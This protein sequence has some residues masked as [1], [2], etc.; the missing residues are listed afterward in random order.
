M[1]IVYKCLVFR[2]SQSCI[3]IEAYNR[4]TKRKHDSEVTNRKHN[5]YFC[6]LRYSDTQIILVNIILKIYV[7]IQ[8]NSP[9][10]C[11]RLPY[12]E[13]GEINLIISPFFIIKHEKSKKKSLK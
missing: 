6:K 7:L 4:I 9:I 8:F 10:V 1:I 5:D 11:L 12:G 2:N 13:N 3:R